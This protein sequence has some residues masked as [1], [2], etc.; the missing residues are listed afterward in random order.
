MAIANN[1]F[2]LNKMKIYISDK[3]QTKLQH[4]LDSNRPGK[5]SVRKYNPNTDPINNVVNKIK[6]TDV[7]R[8][9]HKTG[10]FYTI[11]ISKERL[12]EVK[13]YSWQSHDANKVGYTQPKEGGIIPLLTLIPLILGGVSAAA[14][15]GGMAAGIAKAVNDKRAAEQ[16]AEEQARHN[17]EVEKIAR[18]SGETSETIEHISLPKGTGCKG[19]VN[20]LS[21]VSDEDKTR[22]RN[23]FNAL[24]GVMKIEKQGNGLFLSP[25]S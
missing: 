1:N 14:G 9:K 6:L 16:A 18:G 13:N 7:Q 23:I 20:T 3:T 21:N 2:S 19:F 22:L 4:M 11:Y 17:R 10:K 15:V 24:K 8:I 12:D 25:K 5:I